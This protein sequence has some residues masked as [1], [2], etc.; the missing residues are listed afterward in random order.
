MK[1]FTILSLMLCFTLCVMAQK[2]DQARYNMVKNLTAVQIDKNAAHKAPRKADV[3]TPPSDLVTQEYTL[4]GLDFESE[5]EFELVVNIGIDGNNIYIQGIAADYY[6]PEAWVA[7][8]IND[9]TII[10]P[11]NQFLGNALD[12]EQYPVYFTALADDIDDATL[13]INEDRT[14]TTTDWIIL[15]SKPA[16]TDDDISYYAVMLDIVFT[17]LLKTALPTDV[18]VEPGSTTAA[19]TWTQPDEAGEWALRYRP[20]FDVDPAD[21]MTTWD[22]ET[23][24]QF[25]EWTI[26][27]ADGDG[28]NWAYN[29]SATGGLGLKANSGTGVV[30]SQSYV[31]GSGALTPDNWLISPVVELGGKLKFFA[32]GQD[33]TYFQDTFTVYALEG[34]D[35]TSVDE[36][37]AIS[38]LVTPTN[39]M[40]EYEYDLSAFSGNGRIA[41]RHHNVS[42]MFYLNIDDVTIINADYPITDWTLVEGLT[43]PAY[44]IEGLTEETDYEVQ[45]MAIDDE[46]GESEWTEST[47]FTTTLAETGITEVKSEAAKSDVWYNLQGMKLNGMPTEAGIYINAGKKVVIK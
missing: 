4:S 14:I 27:D 36:F 24:E 2:M 44:L 40:T 17:P 28:N 46:L 32:C 9:N 7:G 35:Y 3:V 30:F 19:V 15:N 25:N 38:E 16:E 26:V 33:K 6:L 10:L 20:Y 42:D 39:A 18:T 31:N 1:K 22:F 8:T 37:T 23:A 11:K 21:Y 34:E 13:T 47:I 41:I 29:N 43:E 5:E 45:V 12:N